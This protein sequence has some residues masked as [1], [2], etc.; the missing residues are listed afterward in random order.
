M[1]IGNINE[2]VDGT[3]ADATDLNQYSD[4]L[5]QDLAPRNTSGV[6]TD[7]SGS[8][9]QSS[10]R[11]LKGWFASIG[12]GASASNNT[13]EEDGSNNVIIKR[14]GSTVAEFASDGVS[15]E[16][17]GDLNIEKSISSGNFSVTGST[18]TDV[19]NLSLTITTSG[20]PVSLI[21]VGDPSNSASVSAERFSSDTNIRVYF[22]RD[23]TLIANF[24]VGNANTG[25][26]SSYCRIDYPPSSFACIDDV[27]AGTYAYKVA[28]QGTGSDTS[29]VFY[30]HLTAHEI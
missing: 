20:N 27:S 6:A 4:A 28:V 23:A 3:V 13:I 14:D 17:F 12:I 18:E 5:R 10:L 26:G 16:Y 19:T 15:R 24:F 11:W 9:G 8:L 1:G 2:I 30:C 22:Y 7:S 21:M 29:R 25:S